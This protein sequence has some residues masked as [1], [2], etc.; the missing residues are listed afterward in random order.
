MNHFLSCSTS[1]FPDGEHIEMAIE[2]VNTFNM[3]WIVLYL[4]AHCICYCAKIYD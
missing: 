2:V 4:L 3:E 1:L